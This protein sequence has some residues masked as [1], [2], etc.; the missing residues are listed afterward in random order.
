[1]FRTAGLSAS[2]CNLALAGVN[3]RSFSVYANVESLDKHFFRRSFNNAN[4]TLYDGTVCDFH[5]SFLVR[6]ERKFGPNKAIETIQAASISLD[7]END[8]V[9]DLLGRHLDLDR[10]YRFWAA[11]V[12][13]GHWDGYVSNKNNYFV[14]LGHK[15][16]AVE[17]S[18]L[19]SRSTGHG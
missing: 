14:Y 4:V 18:P 5:V 11:E 15:I 13:V 10:F 2:R 19:G 7:A 3:G 1:M 9:L 17:F 12:L 8:S 6:F 16:E